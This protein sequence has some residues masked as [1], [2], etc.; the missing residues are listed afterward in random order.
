[1]NQFESESRKLRGHMSACLCVS[2]E[3]YEGSHY[4]ATGSQ[5]TNAKLWDLRMD[6][7]CIKTF[8]G[9]TK[10]VTCVEFSPDGKWICTGSKDGT[11]KVSMRHNTVKIWDISSSKEIHTFSYPEQE[12]TCLQY[13]P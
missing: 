7:P 11:L 9:H 1:M 5:D 2:P 4:V 6:S 10:P 3:N 13:N 8:K 12:V